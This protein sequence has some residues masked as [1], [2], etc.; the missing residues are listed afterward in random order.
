MY[1]YVNN[2]TNRNQL[3]TSGYLIN[4]KIYEISVIKNESKNN[5]V[6]LWTR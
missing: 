5:I 6:R 1:V 4:S 3:V 2:T